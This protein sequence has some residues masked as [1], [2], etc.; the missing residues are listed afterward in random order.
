MTDHQQKIGF[1]VS[2]D[3]GLVFLCPFQSSQVW[4]GSISWHMLPLNT[5]LKSVQCALFAFSVLALRLPRSVVL[6]IQKMD[7]WELTADSASGLGTN[8]LVCSRRWE[9]ISTRISVQTYHSQRITAL[10]TIQA[11]QLD[12]TSPDE[13]DDSNQGCASRRNVARWGR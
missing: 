3:Y 13:A 7:K 6:F 12:A 2:S 1:L 5:L 11:V 8:P 4:P 10:I 9:N